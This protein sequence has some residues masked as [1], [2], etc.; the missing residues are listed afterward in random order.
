MFTTDGDEWRVKIIDFGMSEFTTQSAKFKDDGYKLGM[1]I[2]VC[3]FM[4]WPLSAL[5]RIVRKRL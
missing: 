4:V 1:A 3:A 2:R 5:C